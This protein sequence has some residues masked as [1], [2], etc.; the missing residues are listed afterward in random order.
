M[1]ID[2][3]EPFSRYIFFGAWGGVWLTVDPRAVV[4]P[5]GGGRG[6]GPREVSS[7]GPEDQVSISPLVL[8]HRSH[9]SIPA[10]GPP[11]AGTSAYTYSEPQPR[12]SSSYR[13]ESAC[14]A[15]ALRV[16]GDMSQRW[17]F[18]FSPHASPPPNPNACLNY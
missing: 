12:P 4:H 13:Q 17:K 15:G 11:G 18:V 7:S 3:A 1:G 8:E 16:A 9:M 2:R 6:F 10:A 5:L 14:G